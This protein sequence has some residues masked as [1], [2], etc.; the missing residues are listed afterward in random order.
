MAFPSSNVVR[1]VPRDARSAVPLHAGFAEHGRREMI[2]DLRA[3]EALASHLAVLKDALAQSIAD[4]SRDC[5]A[6]GQPDPHGPLTSLL[7]PVGILEAGMHRLAA[8]MAA[9]LPR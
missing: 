8:A 7:G 2:D 3:L 4:Y 9:Q 6:V 5:V 1:L